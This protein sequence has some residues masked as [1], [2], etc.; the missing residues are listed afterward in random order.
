[1]KIFIENEAGS[2]KKNLF[3]EKTLEYRRTV[4]VSRAYPY[5]YGFILGTT[6]GDGDN[7]DCFILTQ[8]P[9]KSG[10]TVEAEAVGM[11]EDIE[12]GQEDPKI[13]ACLPDEIP[14]IDEKMRMTF[15]DFTTHVFDHIPNKKKEIGR[16]FGVK[17]AEDLINSCKDA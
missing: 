5:P 13:L 12:D 4:E 3:N 10:E 8:R 2:T 15:K 11:F 6:S 1:M 14:I 9:L 17:E 7:L 16:F